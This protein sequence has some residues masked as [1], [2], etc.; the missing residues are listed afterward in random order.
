M[1]GQL[2]GCNMTTG[3]EDRTEVSVFI[4]MARQDATETVAAGVVSGVGRLWARLARWWQRRATAAALARL[5]DRMLRDIG[6]TRHQ[7]YGVA[8]GELMPA[9]A[10]DGAST[11]VQTETPA[12]DGM[13]A[14]GSNDNLWRSRAA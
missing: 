10:D 11:T 8:A 7:L 9:A 5:D 6:L 2:R 12:P 13:P 1:A 4:A 3:Y 14:R